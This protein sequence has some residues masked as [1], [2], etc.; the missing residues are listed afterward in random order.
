MPY[1]LCLMSLAD[2]KGSPNHPEIFK[3]LIGDVI[4]A[5]FLDKDGR[6]WLLMTCGHAIVFSG[7]NA[8]S[9]VYWHELPDGV[10]RAIDERTE[11]VKRKMLDLK[12][13][14]AGLDV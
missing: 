3:H 6:V 11:D 10:K 7:P 4:R 9:P 8:V 1:A 14:V 5:A 13:Q 2:H 12:N